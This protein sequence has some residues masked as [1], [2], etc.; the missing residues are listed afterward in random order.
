MTGTDAA[1]IFTAGL[2]IFNY[3]ALTGKA[4]LAL[5][6]IAIRIFRCTAVR[7]GRHPAGTIIIKPLDTFL[8]IFTQ[9][10]TLGGAAFGGHRGGFLTD[11]AITNLARRAAAVWMGN[12]TFV[13]TRPAGAVGTA[14]TAVTPA[15]GH[16]CRTGIFF[17]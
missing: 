5:R 13:I 8:P 10:F 17:L 4:P 15:V 1:T 9:A 7:W 3:L 11:T 2:G 16:L 6:T 12:V 14:I